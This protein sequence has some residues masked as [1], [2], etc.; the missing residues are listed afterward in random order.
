MYVVVVDVKM[1]GNLKWS[2]LHVSKINVSKT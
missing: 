1:V 2:H